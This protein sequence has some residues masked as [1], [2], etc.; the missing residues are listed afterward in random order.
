MH[1]FFLLHRRA[2]LL[3]FR[4]PVRGKGRSL[5]IYFRDRQ[6]DRLVALA[7]FLARAQARN[8]SLFALWFVPRTLWRTGRLGGVGSGRWG[9][10]RHGG[11]GPGNANK[12]RVSV[13][14]HTPATNHQQY[15]R[16]CTSIL[17]CEHTRLFF[18]S[19]VCSC[20]PDLLCVG[21]RSNRFSQEVEL[22]L[23][24]RRAMAA[25][26]PCMVC[27][28]SLPKEERG[29]IKCVSVARFLLFF[30]P[31]VHTSTSTT[32]ATYAFPLMYDS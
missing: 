10:K 1:S 27:Q 16:P 17:F 20:L 26:G 21:F 14:I 29:I 12:D 32:D 18:F 4:L 9:R 2:V 13:I 28:D 30:T 8:T 22:A 19:R 25:Q 6:Q 24:A 31:H 11:V 3:P 7:I 23:A 5:H 15:T